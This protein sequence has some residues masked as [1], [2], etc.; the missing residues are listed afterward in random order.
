MDDRKADDRKQREEMDAPR[1]LSAAKESQV[2]G[3]ARGE[4]RRHRR[5]GE[6][7]QRREHEHDAGVCELLE[8]VVRM[9]RRRRAHVQIRP[10]VAGCLG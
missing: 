1:G 4:R 7:Q 10:C 5:P 9:T 3:V 8:R 6:H 2:P